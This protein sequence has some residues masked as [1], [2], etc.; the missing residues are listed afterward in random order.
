MRL[1]P[2][3]A[4]VL[5]LCGLTVIAAPAGAGR[6]MSGS[7]TFAEVSSNTVSVQ[8]V[9]D[10]TVILQQNVIQWTGPINGTA[11]ETL[12]VV[13]PPTGDAS[14]YGVDVCSCTDR[15][16]RTGVVT[17]T[18][19]GRDNGTTFHGRLRIAEAA[20]LA[21]LRPGRGV[22]DGSDAAPITGTYSLGFDH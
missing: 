5:A 12:T 20:G 13:A 17:I 22:F 9:G 10:N 19:E 15:Y 6:H 14:F 16:G 4:V 3:V 21:G 1:R 7:G 18:V 8:T 2:I 11:Q